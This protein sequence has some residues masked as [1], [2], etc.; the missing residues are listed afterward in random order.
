MFY[1]VQE[2]FGPGCI[3]LLQNAV[4]MSLTCPLSVFTEH[5]LMNQN[6]ILVVM[7]RELIFVK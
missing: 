3:I 6:H 1:L 5:N 4:G 7:V 2:S